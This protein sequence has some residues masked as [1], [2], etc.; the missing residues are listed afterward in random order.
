MSCFISG[1][2]AK[3]N[4]GSSS[5]RRANPLA[6]FSSSPFALGTIAIEIEGA[7]NSIFGNDAFILLATSVSLVCVFFSLTKPPIIPLVSW[8]VSF[9]SFPLIENI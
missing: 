2:K 1:S 5:R 9:F 6:T 7:G 8:L 4:V 3:V